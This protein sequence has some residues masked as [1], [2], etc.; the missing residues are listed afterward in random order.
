MASTSEDRQLKVRRSVRGRVY[1]D[2]TST[3]AVTVAT[4]QGISERRRAQTR[5]PCPRAFADHRH[6]T[7]D[8]AVADDV[9]I[10]IAGLALRQRGELR[11]CT[12]LVRMIRDEHIGARLLYRIAE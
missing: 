5:E 10:R 3:V 12:V 7:R 9:R 4:G 11:V 6:V 2:V 1:G 8:A